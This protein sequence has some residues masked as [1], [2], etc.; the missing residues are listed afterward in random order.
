MLIVKFLD[1]MFWKLKPK[2]FNLQANPELTF[3][4]SYQ[5]LSRFYQKLGSVW[6]WNF[7]K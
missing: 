4:R 2:S 3:R 7:A 5:K 1:V 6:F